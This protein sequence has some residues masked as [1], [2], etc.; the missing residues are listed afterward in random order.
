[1]GQSVDGFVRGLFTFFGKT[2][3]DPDNAF[4]DIDSYGLLNL[5]GGLRDPDG[6]WEITAFA[7]NVLRERQ[8]LDV[9]ASPLQQTFRTAVPTFVSE[10]RSVGLTAPRE[11]GIT[12]KIAFGSR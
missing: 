2:P 4:D 7:K 10:Y 6:A 1:V 8:L 11:F 5:Y 9:G 12:A 3:N